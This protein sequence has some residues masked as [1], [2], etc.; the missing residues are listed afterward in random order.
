[1]SYMFTRYVGT[2]QSRGLLSY[3][4]QVLREDPSPALKATIKAVG[5]ASISRAH[6][7]PDLKYAAGMEYSAALLATSRA[8]QNAAAAKSDSTLAAVVMLSTYEV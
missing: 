6:S 3:L 2:Q 1:M 4:P 5:L 8:L 7:L